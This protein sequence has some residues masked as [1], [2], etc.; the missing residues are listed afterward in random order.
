M[1]GLVPWAFSPRTSSVG[2]H[3][4]PSNHIFQEL[5]DG[6]NTWMPG[7]GRNRSGHDGVISERFIHCRTLCSDRVSI[8]SVE[9]VDHEQAGAFERSSPEGSQPSRRALGRFSRMR[10]NASFES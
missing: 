6:R 4:V 9:A 10:Q 3:A 2:I 7:T 5:G 8:I 1:A